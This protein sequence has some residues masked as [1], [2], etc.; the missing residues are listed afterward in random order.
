MPR[1]KVWWFPSFQFLPCPPFYRVISG[2]RSIGGSDGD[3]GVE[4]RVF[5]FFFPEKCSS[6]V[7]GCFAFTSKRGTKLGPRFKIATVY[8]DPYFMYIV[9]IVLCVFLLFSYRL[10]GEVVVILQVHSMLCLY[11]VKCWCLDNHKCVPAVTLGISL[12]QHFTIDLHCIRTPKKVTSTRP[13]IPNPKRCI[14]RSFRWL[15]LP[16]ET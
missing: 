16:R 11:S 3:Y 15:Y 8:P 14:C 1:T 7:L 2:A 5:V 12:C 9:L 13:K 4:I 10:R 6:S